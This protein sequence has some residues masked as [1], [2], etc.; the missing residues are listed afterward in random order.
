MAGRSFGS[1]RNTQDGHTPAATRNAVRTFFVS[2]P[3]G[4]RR[5]IRFMAHHEVYP[6]II[7]NVNELIEPVNQRKNAPR[8]KRMSPAKSLTNE[9]RAR[10][11]MWAGLLLTP[12]ERQ[13][14]GEA[15][16]EILRAG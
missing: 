9:A 8:T 10:M 13:I 7:V 1:Q 5:S 16:Q 14:L 6:A 12:V 15:T 4:T 2:L 11:Q 3:S